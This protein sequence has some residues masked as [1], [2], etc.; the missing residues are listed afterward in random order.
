MDMCVRRWDARG[1][2][3]EA[4][5]LEASRPAFGGFTNRKLINAFPAGSPVAA[6]IA[7]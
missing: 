2:V 3:P 1:A 4:R 5:S 7:A 6:T